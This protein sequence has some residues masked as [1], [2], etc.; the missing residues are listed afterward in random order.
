MNQNQENQKRRKNDNG[1]R[2]IINPEMILA[3]LIIVGLMATVIANIRAIPN[4]SDNVSDNTQKIGIIETKI[5]FIL[6]GVKEIKE[7]LKE[8]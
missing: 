6:D 1:F 5:E 2:R 8:K 3:V 7:I 4:L